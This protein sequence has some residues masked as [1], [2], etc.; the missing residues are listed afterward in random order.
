M[1]KKII[2]KKH[3]LFYTK[4]H[5]W[6]LVNDIANYLKTNLHG[7]ILY[8][9]QDIE[10]AY[11]F[12]GIRGN[13]LVITRE[14]WL[15]LL[16]KMYYSFSEVALDYPD[17][18]FNLWWTENCRVISPTFKKDG[19]LAMNTPLLPDSVKKETQ[20]Y[21][22]R[23]QEGVSLYVKYLEYIGDAQL[24]VFPPQITRGKKWRW[25]QLQ[26]T[27]EGNTWQDMVFPNNQARYIAEGIDALRKAKLMG[28]PM[29]FEEKQWCNALDTMSFSFHELVFANHRRMFIGNEQEYYQK[30]ARGLQFFEK[31]FFDL[32]D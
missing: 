3:L 12:H 22:E 25:L 18:P 31:S 16:K 2:Q 20:T 23:I 1:N 13:K 10:K 14:D 9:E 27:N 26:K 24:E 6:S 32:W 15:A 29:G 11:S 30:I 4:R 8:F 17:S 21:Y 5:P 19:S 7:Y 28:H